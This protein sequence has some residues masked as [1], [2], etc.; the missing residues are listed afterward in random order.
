MPG[1]NDYFKAFKE[2]EI[3]GNVNGGQSKKILPEIEM[4]ISESLKI[5]LND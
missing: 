5:K 1:I 4:I 2:D 3:Q